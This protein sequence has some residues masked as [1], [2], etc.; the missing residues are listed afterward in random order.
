MPGV[1]AASRPAGQDEGL[2]IMR[3]L[4]SC[5]GTGAGHWWS[6]GRRRSLFVR[7]EDE[8]FLLLVA[9]LRVEVAAGR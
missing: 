4:R 3:M 9:A 6:G 1:I 5:A 8:V 7:G 2:R